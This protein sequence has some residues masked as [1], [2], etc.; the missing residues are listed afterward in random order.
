MIVIDTLYVHTSGAKILL[1]YLISN[2]PINHSICLLLDKRNTVMF[3]SE[4]G[5]SRVLKGHLERY[6]FYK[7]N[8]KTI[9]RVLCFANIPPP[10]EL[11]AI[12]YTY[13]HQPLYLTYYSRQNK[14]SLTNELKKIILGFFAKNTNVWIT[15]SD[16]IASLLKSDFASASHEL[17]VIPFYEPMSPRNE[18]R[19]ESSF[20]YVSKGYKHK[21]HLRLLKAFS[22]LI[23]SGFEAKLYLTLDEDLNEESGEIRQ[24]LLQYPQIINLGFI[25]R[26]LLEGMY[27]KVEYI[28]YPSLAESFGLG[29]IEG[30]L[31]GCDVLVADL[32]Y[33]HAVCDASVYFN[34]RSSE[35]IF[36]ALISV[37]TGDKFQ[38]SVLKAEN[39]IGELLRL[40]F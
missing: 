17:K 32:P 6:Y 22:K 28:I 20:L 13:F 8:K 18:K 14:F 33:A 35:S 11:E 9:T 29:L 37:I 16:H 30:I 4:K 24:Y 27:S 38:K 12:V 26:D 2:I 3:P 31:M 40:L 23:E 25:E 1:D 34:P 5:E 19:E 7:K 36:D 21:N 15:Q 10:I 39:Q